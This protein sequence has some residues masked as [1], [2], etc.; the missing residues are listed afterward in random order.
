VSPRPYANTAAVL[1]PQECVWG[2]GQLTTDTETRGKTRRRAGLYATTL[3][4]TK[5]HYN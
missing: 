4:R 1:L 5:S 2:S 3:V